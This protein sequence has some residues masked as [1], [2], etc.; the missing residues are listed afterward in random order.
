[1]RLAIPLCKNGKKRNFQDKI[2]EAWRM[3]FKLM[4][5][6]QKHHKNYI[7]MNL[8]WTKGFK[9]KTEEDNTKLN[10]K[11]EVDLTIENEIPHHPAQ[12]HLGKPPI[13]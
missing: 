4:E 1:M 11:S 8:K 3:V 7:P 12:E 10:K 2:K 6:T 9:A 5:D 13:H